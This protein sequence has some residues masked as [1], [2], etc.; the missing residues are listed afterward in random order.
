MLEENTEDPYLLRGSQLSTTLPS[1]EIVVYHLLKTSAAR[2]RQS[3]KFFQFPFLNEFGS[4]DKGKKNVI[5]IL[6]KVSL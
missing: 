3:S 2:N 6:G 4:S 5:R 1:K